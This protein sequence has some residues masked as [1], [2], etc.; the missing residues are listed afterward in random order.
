MNGTPSEDKQSA[1]ES[2]KA[3]PDVKPSF[4]KR[5]PAVI[6]GTVV[7]AVAFFF[8][9]HYVAYSLTHETTDDAFLDGDVISIA[10]KVAGQVKKVY[11]ADNQPV[12]AADV[13]VEIDPSDYKVQLAQK[14]ATVAASESN[15][16]LIFASLDLF[17]A[18]IQSAEASIRQAE[19]Q[20]AASQ[21]NAVKAS[22]D[23]K[24]DEA[25]F[26]KQIISQADFDANKATADAATATARADQE[27]IA[28]QQ[29]KEGQMKAELE[30][31]LQGLARAQAQTRQ[32]ELDAQAADLNLSYTRVLAPKD[33]RVTR[34]AVQ[35]GDYVQVGQKLMALVLDSI[36]VTANFKETQLKNIR[37]NQP[38]EIAIDSVGGKIFSGHVESIQAGS[39][40][41][42]SLLPPENAVGN[43]VKVVQRVPVKI[44]F[45]PAIETW[46]ALGPGMSVVPSI[47]VSDHEPSD[48]V[49]AIIAA[50]LA[51]VVGFIWWKSARRR[52]P[53]T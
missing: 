51:W 22:A 44:V 30:A 27:N 10:P 45:D 41:A 6:V 29:A 1:E 2:Q 49:V 37:T 31:G 42:F 40:A 11:V 17:R 53:Q 8:G 20:A 39:G 25:L 9:V 16:K 38:V 35:D 33:G 52:K 24:R 34:K 36:W 13:L 14:Q 43:Y 4:W 50:A 26:Q 28:N 46:H 32:S 15:S 21:A 47:K 18:Q 19:A 23:L 12:K 5:T 7:L 3:Q 48:V